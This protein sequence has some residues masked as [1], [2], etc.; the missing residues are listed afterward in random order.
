M[1]ELI[2]LH[3]H[4]RLSLTFVTKIARLEKSVPLIHSTVSIGTKMDGGKW[5]KICLS[6]EQR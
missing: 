6:N 5:H 2:D 4:C 3:F 1:A